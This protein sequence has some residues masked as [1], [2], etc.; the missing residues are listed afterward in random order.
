MLSP[1]QWE[2]D[3]S[4]ALS[5]CTSPSCHKKAIHFQILHLYS[6]QEDGKEKGWCQHYLFPSSREENAFQHQPLPNK[7]RLLRCHWWEGGH[8]APPSWKEGWGKEEFVSLL[9]TWEGQEW[10]YAT[11]PQLKYDLGM[12]R[13]E[14]QGGAREERCKYKDG[15]AR[16]GLDPS[17]CGKPGGGSISLPTILIYHS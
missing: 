12:G 5:T 14:R 8:M 9:S 6:R 1:Q 10:L 7:S 13:S 4:F 11:A 2:G 15:E 3:C 16:L 17:L